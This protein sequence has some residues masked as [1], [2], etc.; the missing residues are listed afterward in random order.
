MTMMNKTRIYDGQILSVD[1]IDFLISIEPD[2]DCPPPWENCDGHGAISMR[3]ARSGEFAEYAWKKPYQIFLGATRS[4]G[5]P[6]HVFYDVQESIRVAKRDGWNTAP[7][8]W[9]TKGEQADAAVRADVRYLAG[10]LSGKWEYSFITV[11]ALDDSGDLLPLSDS[12]GGVEYDETD[13]SY[14]LYE[15]EML[16]RQIIAEHS[17]MFARPLPRVEDVIEPDE[18]MIDDSW[19]IAIAA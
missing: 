12:I 5:H 16:C 11:H 1:G 4:N 2:Q 3:A 10:Y 14:A 15:A 6:M 19:A 7:Y 18:M 9:K 13:S 17:G 8:A